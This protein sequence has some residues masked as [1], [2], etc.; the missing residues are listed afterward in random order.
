M[1][2]ADVVVPPGQ[3]PD[4]D[5]HN[6]RVRRWAASIRATLEATVPR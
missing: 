5:G 6:D 2:V 1:T 4:A 3:M